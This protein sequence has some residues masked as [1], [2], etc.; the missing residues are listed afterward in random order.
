MSI[1][2]KINCFRGV[3]IGSKLLPI[4]TGILISIHTK[5]GK[6]ELNVHVSLVPSILSAVAPEVCPL[7]S[8]SK[9]LG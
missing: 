1:V 7:I 2:V 4:L 8:S 5:A 3:E 9:Q 6:R